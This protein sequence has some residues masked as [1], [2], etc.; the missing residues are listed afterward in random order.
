MTIH[1]R[2]VADRI[3]VILIA[4]IS[5]LLLFYTGLRAATMSFTI[6]ESLSYN[7]YSSRSF[8]D[9]ISYSPA[10][11]NNHMIN[12]LCIKIISLLPSANEFLFRLPS[13]LSHLI[14][15]IISFRIVKKT[16]SPILIICGFLL[17]NLNPYMLDFFSLARGYA[18]ALTF[19]ISS[20]YFLISYIDN[21]KTKYINWSICFAALAVLCN[22]TLLIFYVSLIA[23]INIYW[24]ASENKFNLKNF[25]KANKTVLISCV[26]LAIILFEPIRKLTKNQ[27][28]YD[29]GKTGFWSDTVGSL[30]SATLYD[31]SHIFDMQKYITIF[32]GLCII[33][34][35]ITIIYKMFTDKW[36]IFT[37]KSSITLLLLLLTCLVSI[38]QHILLG[39]NFLRNRMG[40]FLIPMFF[41]PIIL[42]IDR[43]MNPEKLKRSGWT[44]VIIVAAV[45]SFNTIISLNKSYTLYWK[46]D[47]DTKEML[48]DIER[49][50]KSEGSETK[51]LGTIW[52]YKPTVKFYKEVKK[53]D[54]LKDI[55]D[56][57]YRNADYDYYFLADSCMTFINSHKLEIIKHYTNSNMNLLKK[58]EIN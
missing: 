2:N 53:Y 25:F 47:S 33:I 7:L 15:I 38:M 30:I 44:I 36:K 37:E 10:I 17:L 45:F 49:Q 21:H 51:S 22:F 27:E 55:S 48:S 50:T 16:S 20:I 54:W 31:Q 12:S 28:F 23:V 1:Y 26:L 18:M 19:C 11:A 40:L 13:L 8:M 58:N 34:M 14:Y 52:L 5:L 32:V 3:T 4:I 43:Y 29:G 6:D 57:N 42:F 9:I 24:I 41:I 46:Y 39:S 35:C 56:E